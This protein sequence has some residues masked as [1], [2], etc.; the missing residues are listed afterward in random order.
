M[1]GRVSEISE[2]S[3]YI[4]KAW[5]L[6]WQAWVIYIFLLIVIGIAVRYLLR[7]RIKKQKH[8]LMQKL[9]ASREKFLKEQEEE[10]EKKLMHLE[11]KRLAEQ[12]KMKKRELSNLAT[13]IVY[14]NEVLNNL[15]EELLNLRDTEGKEF[16]KDQLKKI[17]RLMDKARSDERDW[18]IFEK[19]FN[20]SHGDFFKKLKKNYPSLTPNDLKLCAYLRLNMTSKEVASLFNI[21][22]RGVEVRRYR[23]RKKFNLET[24]TN[25]TEFLLK[26]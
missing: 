24:E 20:E 23:L 16:S 9:R 21:T 5:Y 4:N 7:K 12:L 2:K 25:L 11:N 22:I 14:K 26:L 19:S 17:D 8:Q 1:E 13:N 3:F 18:D 6:Q 10:N 15:R